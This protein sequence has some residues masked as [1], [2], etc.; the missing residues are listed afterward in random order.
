MAKK[1]LTS[2]KLHISGGVVE[3]IDDEWC[4]DGKPLERDVQI[5]LDAACL[6][7]CSNHWAGKWLLQAIRVSIWGKWDILIDYLE[8]IDGT[9]KMVKF[10]RKHY[11]WIPKRLSDF[12]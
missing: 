1:K 2:P 5:V 11:E 10:V 8:A 12:Q 3:I 6:W 4:F 7:A 9:D